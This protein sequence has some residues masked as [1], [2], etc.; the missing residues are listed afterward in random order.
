MITNKYLTPRIKKIDLV[1]QVVLKLLLMMSLAPLLGQTILT[2]SIPYPATELNVR[3]Y[4]A[5]VNGISAVRYYHPIYSGSGIHVSVKEFLF[6]TN[7]VDLIKNYRHLETQLPIIQS[8]STIIATLI[9]GRGNHGPQSLGVA[10]EVTLSSSSFV[11]A[12]PDTGDFYIRHGI[13]VQNHSYGTNILNLYGSGAFAF[14]QQA[15]RDQ[16]VLHVF[17]SGNQ[18]ISSAMGGVY[19]GLD[20]ISNITGEF[21]H[22]K[23]TICIGSVDTLDRIEQNS[24][25]GP[26]YDG[27]IKPELVAYSQDGTSSAAAL[28][29]GTAALIQEVYRQDHLDSLPQASLVKAILINSAD[30]LGPAGPDHTYGFGKLNALG[31]VETILDQSYTLGRLKKQETNIQD[32]VLEDKVKSLKVTLVWHEKPASPSSAK[33]LVH[34]LDLSIAYQ[35]STYYLPLV[36]DPTPSKTELK[37]P[38]QP[39]IDTLNNIEQIMIYYPSAGKYQLTVHNKD[40]TKDTV[41]Y[42]LVYHVE[43]QNEFIWLSPLTTESISASAV[44]T[45]RWSSSYADSVQG[46]LAMSYD[47]IQ[48][49]VIAPSLDLHQGYFKWQA[50]DTNVLAFFKMDIEGKSYSTSTFILQDLRI[51]T[52]FVCQDSVAI[53]WKPLPGVAEYNISALDDLTFSPITSTSDTF[54][55]LPLTPYS[56]VAVAPVIKGMPGPRY[57]SYTYIDQ[58]TFCYIKNFIGIKINERSAQIQLEIGTTMGIKSI[59]IDRITSSGVASILNQSAALKPKYNP[60]T[61]LEK[62]LNKI[63][64][65]LLLLN[66]KT[67][68]EELSLFS[69]GDQLATIYPNP[70]YTGQSLTFTSQIPHLLTALISDVRGNTLQIIDELESGPLDLRDLSPGIYFIAIFDGRQLIFRDKLLVY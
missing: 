63:R 44:S 62:G 69:L 34:D 50:P 43:A 37:K 33:A 46:S 29:S 6:D 51:Q 60:T 47:S 32:I 68:T 36:L 10:P 3:D 26:A 54:V 12:L 56:L 39:G 61:N 5:R 22:S 40:Q 28:V 15:Y 53:F 59:M 27:R 20:S 16:T 55:V 4:N 30:D 66:G 57:S 11:Q 18:G 31:A 8:H 49:L 38:A 2:K 17:S 58:G 42:S 21:K 7:D 64:L 65:T 52:G 25:R 35:D 70:A 13:S 19:D 48:W 14:D 9:G 1:S 41:A 45:L 23:N 24:S 67:I